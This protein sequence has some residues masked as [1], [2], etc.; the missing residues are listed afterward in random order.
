MKL[1]SDDTLNTNTTVSNN[2]LILDKNIKETYKQQKVN[3]S[4]INNEK[5]LP[6][7]NAEFPIL[8]NN[9]NIFYNFGLN[10]YQKNAMHNDNTNIKNINP[11]MLNRIDSSNI[12]Y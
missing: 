4:T 11:M 6:D 7:S 8:G 2:I 10:F 5:K 9:S 3:F 12:L 1:F